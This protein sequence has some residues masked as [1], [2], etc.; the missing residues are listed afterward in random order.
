MSVGLFWWSYTPYSLGKLI[1]WKLQKDYINRSGRGILSPYSLGKLI[2][3]KLAE[4]EKQDK[5][6]DMLPTR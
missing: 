3:W 6:I 1:D 2:D 5:Q 4:A